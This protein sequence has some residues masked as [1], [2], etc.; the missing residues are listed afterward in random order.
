M[1]RAIAL[2][3]A[4]AGGYPPPAWSDPPDLPDAGTTEPDAGS[5]AGQPNS[6]YS[7]A[8][9]GPAEDSGAPRTVGPGSGGPSVDPLG[10]SCNGDC[11]G[12]YA[13]YA[14]TSMPPGIC[15]PYCGDALPRCPGGYACSRSLKACVPY[16]EE[17]D[18]GCSVPRAPS[19][20]G[21]GAWLLLGALLVAAGRAR[22]RAPKR[23]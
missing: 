23:G 8:D 18:G 17:D 14:A 4:T 1:I 11:P 12:N 6:D 2:D 9:A 5:D 22:R 16:E 13:C 19:T 20:T 3:A 10:L 7:S 21:N 15:V